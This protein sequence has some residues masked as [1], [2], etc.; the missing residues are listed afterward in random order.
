MP[1]PIAFSWS[2]SF[3]A[4]EQEN[5]YL[6]CRLLLEKT[7]RRKDL[8]CLRESLRP[9]L[10]ANEFGSCMELLGAHLYCNIRMSHEIVIPFRM[11]WCAALRGYRQV[12]IVIRNRHQGINPLL[13]GLRSLRC[14][15]DQ[16]RSACDLPSIGAKLLDHFHVVLNKRSI[17]H[18]LYLLVY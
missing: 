7:I 3:H 4:F 14:H 10:A 13:P 6:V 5:G 1:S 2:S 12:R 17:F 8:G 16:W 9:L 18:A 15:E 11:L